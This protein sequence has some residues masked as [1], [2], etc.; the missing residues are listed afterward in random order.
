LLLSIVL[1]A[2]TYLLLRVV[3]G[4]IPNQLLELPS[5]NSDSAQTLSPS[6]A[7]LAAVAPFLAPFAEELTFRYLLLGKLTNKALRLIMLFVQGILFGLIHWNNFNGNIYA[8]IPYMVLGVYL[9]LIYLFS[10]NIWSPIMVHWMLNTMNAMLP[11]LL[12]LILSLFGI[13]V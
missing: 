5:S 11:A 13:K 10:K 2:G 12:L 1:V 7:V 6:W 3:R 4:L 8:M 9:G